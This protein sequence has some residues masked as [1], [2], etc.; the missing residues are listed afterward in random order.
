[1]SNVKVSTYV[2]NCTE[3][4]EFADLASW[5]IPQVPGF[6]YSNVSSALITKAF[7]HP[8]LKY[9]KSMDVPYEQDTFLVN[10]PVFS[11]KKK[12]AMRIAKIVDSLYE[13]ALFPPV[14]LDIS[15]DSMHKCHTCMPVGHHRVRALQYMNELKVPCIFSKVDMSIIRSLLPRPRCA[16]YY[17][18]HI[19]RIT[20]AAI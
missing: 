20:S 4:I 15:A 19:G 9:V 2:D 6:M 8:D 16:A 1:M 11:E 13:G 7:N 14:I 3:F 18:E 10:H 17:K 5:E 12:H